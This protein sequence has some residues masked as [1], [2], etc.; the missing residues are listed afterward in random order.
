MR[1]V[2]V[3]LTAAMV[4]ILALTFNADRVR[5]ADYEH[6]FTGASKCRICHMSDKKGDQYGAWQES[7]HS[8]AYE[9]LT[10]DHSKEVAKEAGVSGDPAE[11][12]ECLRCHVTGID[13]SDEMRG[14]KWDKTEGVS[15][16]SCHGPGEDY[17][18]MKVMRDREASIAAGLVIPTV[19]TCKECH[20]EE[21][22]TYKPFNCGEFWAET[23]HDNPQT[24]DFGTELKGCN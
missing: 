16:E 5:G 1:T 11:A 2:T 17:S 12:M 20:N 22:P 13:A 7:P 4:M 10:T 9:T 14:D 18:P 8:K 15:C 24:E 21:S 6:A 3:L 23:V 19:E